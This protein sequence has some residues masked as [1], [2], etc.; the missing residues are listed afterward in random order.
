MLYRLLA[1]AVVILHLLFVL[2]VVAGGLLALRWP[3]S[4]W[5]HVPAVTWGVLLEFNGWPCPLTPLEQGLRR[6]GGE[7]GYA[8]GFVDH[9]LLPVLYPA[10][11]DRDMA[12]WLGVLVLVIN[13]L[14]YGLL[15]RVYLKRRKR[16]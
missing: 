1:D 2:Y 6:A 16:A 3:R 8:G 11:L 14:V 9:Y 12:L 4:L 10:G 13:A 15:L 5:L 7:A